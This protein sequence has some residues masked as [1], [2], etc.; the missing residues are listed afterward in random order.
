MKVD[1][2]PNFVRQL[3]KLPI[4]LQSKVVDKVDLFKQDWQAPSLKTHKLKGR[5]KNCWSFSVDYSH[6]V[7]F[8]KDNNHCILVAVGDHDVYR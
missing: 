2:T 8:Q 5:I 7:V 6:R 1:F 4:S 3:R